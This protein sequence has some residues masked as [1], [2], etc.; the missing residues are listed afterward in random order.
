M[1]Y[2]DLATA[3]APAVGLWSFTQA[4]TATWKHSGLFADMVEEFVAGTDA[5]VFAATTILLEKLCT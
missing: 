3:A 1:Y 2:C 4:I 5:E